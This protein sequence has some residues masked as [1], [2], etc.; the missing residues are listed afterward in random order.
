MQIRERIIAVLK[1]VYDPEIPVDIYELGL[2]YGVEVTDDGEAHVTMTLTRRCARSPRRLPPE[3]ED[4]V[5]NVIGVKD[6]SSRSRLGSAVECGHDVGRGAPRTQ[7]DVDSARAL[8]GLAAAAFFA[9]GALLV[10]FGANAT[11]H[12]PRRSPS[13]TQTSRT[14]RLDALAG[15]RR[16]GFSVAGPLL[17]PACPAAPSSSR[18]CRQAS[19]IAI[20]HGRT[21]RPPSADAAHR[22]ARPPS[23]SAPDLYETLLNAA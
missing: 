4:K 5:R 17:G 9:F 13:T 20:D 18:L 10:L 1:T 19:P 3:V 14:R 2:V 12:R 22:A 23:A 6:V 16:A 15:P 7:P 8:N 11:E 21:V